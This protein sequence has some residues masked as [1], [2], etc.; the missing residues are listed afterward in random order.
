MLDDDLAGLRPRPLTGGRNNRVF[1]WDSPDGEVCLKLYRT[2]KRDRAACEYQ[3]L[4]HVAGRGVTAGPQPLWHDPDPQLPAV[5]MSMLPGQPVPDLREPTTALR[6]IVA[7]LGQLRDIPLGPFADMARVDSATNYMTRITDAWPSQL[8]EHDEPL[9]AD[10]RSLLDAWHEHGDASALAEPAPRI[11][12]RGDSNLFNWLW[13]EP[14]I[15][16]VDWEFAGYSD[17]AYDAAEFVEHLSAHAID[18]EWWISLL[19]DL[20]INHDAI[21]RRFLAAQ[22]TVA[23]RWLSVLWKR[24]DKRADEF[25][26]QLKRVRKLMNHDFL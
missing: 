5:A 23:L 11:F 18:D 6:A 21:R 1:A 15:H 14:D 24:R 8:D 10:M 2:D 25:E 17:T 9:T 20:G 19:P 3:A 4:M 13:D 7:V 26:Y 22:R 12:S 16:V